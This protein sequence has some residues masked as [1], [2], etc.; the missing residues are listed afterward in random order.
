MTL[1]SSYIQQ[2]RR[3]V[4]MNGN[5]DSWRAGTSFTNVTVSHT[6][7]MTL[8]TK[9]GQATYNI[10]ADTS[11]LPNSLS[12][13][14]HKVTVTAAESTVAAGDHSFVLIRIEGYDFVPLIGKP[15][16]LSFWVRS[17]VPGTY[18]VALRNDAADRSF[19]Q[20]YTINESNTWEYKTIPMNLNFSGGTWEYGS[21]RGLIIYWGICNGTDRQ[22][23]TTGAWLSGNYLTTSNQVNGAASINNTFHLA[24][25]QLEI[26]IQATP[27]ER[28]PIGMLEE[29]MNRYYFSRYLYINGT[30]I[31]TGTGNLYASW[32]F[33]SVMRAAPTMS[34]PTTKQMWA[35]T[36]YTAT[37][38]QMSANSYR[39]LCTMQYTGVSTYVAR[40]HG[41]MNVNPIIADARL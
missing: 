3:N 27:F 38:F 37:G 15:V 12:Q 7:L 16:T 9:S 8:F 29:M 35:G 6:A 19:I 40:A 41:L 25:C 30:Q 20:E 17:S 33:P 5:F 36:W 13:Y 1:H 23:D 10:N 2:G 31:Q 26:G 18:C 24:Q 11:S 34:A 4:L 28:L 14:A 22:S 21:G 39:C 32:D